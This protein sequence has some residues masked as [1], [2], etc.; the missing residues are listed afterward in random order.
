MSQETQ[1]PDR[2]AQVAQALFLANIAIAAGQIMR[3]V[4][5]SPGAPAPRRW[6]RRWTM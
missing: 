1:K 5:A 4:E 6:Q 3:K 2:A